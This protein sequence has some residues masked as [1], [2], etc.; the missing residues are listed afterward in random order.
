MTKQEI[1]IKHWIDLNIKTPFGICNNTGYMISYCVNGIEDIIAEFP[2]IK[3]KIE[4]EHSE[5]DLIKWKPKSLK[6]IEDN[7]GWIKIETIDDL[8]K[9]IGTDCWFVHNGKKVKGLYLDNTFT[10]GF[11]HFKWETISHYYPIV[12]PEDYIY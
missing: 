7:N 9:T 8:P 11:T 6:G 4:F 12:E 2:T 5:Y 10:C 1:I 3:D